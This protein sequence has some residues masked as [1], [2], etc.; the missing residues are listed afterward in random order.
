MVWRADAPQ[1]DESAKIRFEALPYCLGGFDLGC[2]SRKVWPHMIGVD[3]RIDERLFGMQTNPNLVVSDCASMPLF[4][5]ACAETIFSSHLLE[6]IINPR[7]AL[8]EWW[9]L[10]KPGGHLVLYLPHADFYPNIGQPGANPDHK[11]DFRPADVVAMMEAIA[12]DWTLLE[13]QERNGGNEYSFFQVFRKELAGAGQRHAWSE[14]KPPLR[15]GVVRF[16]G[17]G[18]ALW[19]SSPIALLKERGYHVTV[20]T[21]PGGGNV[22]RHDPHID[23][24]VVLPDGALAQEELLAWYAHEAVKFDKWVNLIG[25][26]ETRLLAHAN[27]VGF[28]WPHKLRNE[29]MA[30]NY[31]EAVHRFADLPFDF[32]QKFYP[33][34]AEIE[35]RDKMR[36]LLPGPLVVISPSGSSPA[37][38]WPHSQRLMELLAARGVFSVVLGN[39]L[40][41]D[42][43]GVDPFGSVVGLDWPL[44][45]ALTFAQGAD[46]VVAT[47]SAIGNSVAFEE[48]LKLVTL[49]HSSAENLTKHW[50]NTIALEPQGIGCHPC[51]RIH[52]SFAFCARDTNTGA[53]A[54]LA[55]AS[56]E[57]VAE[58]LFDYLERTG[59]LK[60]V[61]A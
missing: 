56:A 11:H 59:K 61:A 1:G 20:Y 34:P 30:E 39:A 9:R 50:R 54:C 24:L 46:A 47:E 42:V 29:L 43:V 45:S 14:P 60:K 27:E 28:Y 12:P 23:R 8:A 10:V 41:P 40:G 49:S 53:A 33:T 16:G 51:H 5:D 37:K 48:M 55:V 26:V 3:N 19:S 17:H 31:L 57:L 52:A 38:Y 21:T 13:N 25:S 32:R 22:L 44:R 6:H 2:G 18:D 7:A 4:A 36:A 35:W 15:A 58:M